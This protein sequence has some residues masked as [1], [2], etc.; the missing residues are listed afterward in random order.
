[1]YFNVIVMTIQSY[2][3]SAIFRLWSHPPHYAYYSSVILEILFTPCCPLLVIDSLLKYTFL[4]VLT[5]YNSPVLCLRIYCLP[6]LPLQHNFN[7]TIKFIKLNFYFCFHYCMVKGRNCMCIPI[8]TFVHFCV[9]A[10]RTHGEIRLNLS[11]IAL[12]LLG[13]H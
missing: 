13:K 3:S 9:R 10:L 7:V 5:L 12:Y 8:V 1:M 4:W 11:F 6:L 2:C